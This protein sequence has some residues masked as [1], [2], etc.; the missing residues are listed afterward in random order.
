M[1]N[2]LASLDPNT[3]RPTE[4][5]TEAK[6]ALP[7]GDSTSMDI[8][9]TREN[10]LPGRLEEASEI[11]SETE[12]NEH[13]WSTEP[14][15]SMN[16]LMLQLDELEIGAPA[17]SMG[18]AGEKT[19]EEKSF[20][21]RTDSQPP[22]TQGRSGIVNRTEEAPDSREKENRPELSNPMG[23]NSQRIFSFFSQRISQ[24]TSQGTRSKKRKKTDTP[25]PVAMPATKKQKISISP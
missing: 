10:T 24:A 8:N 5:T 2:P 14:Q 16:D 7:P 13:S 21:F 12:S 23:Q 18:R 19:N 15:L 25:S 20:S 4:T 3:L 11:E 22:R 9:S 17:V 1:R 6:L